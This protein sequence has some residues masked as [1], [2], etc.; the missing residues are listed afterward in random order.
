M[1]TSPALLL[2]YSVVAAVIGALL[3]HRMGEEQALQEIAKSIGGKIND[4]HQL[5]LHVAGELHAEIRRRRTDPVFLLPLLE[6]LGASP[7]AVLREGGCCSGIARLYILILDALGIRAAQVTLYHCSG[8]AVHCLVEVALP[9]G[10]LIVDPMYGFS[11]E[12]SDGRPLGLEDLQQG[13]QPFFKSLPRSKAAA[14]PGDSYYHFSF[15][16]SKTA[17]WTKSKLRRTAYSV[18]RSLTFGRVDR[19]RLSPVLEWPQVLLGLELLAGAAGTALFLCALELAGP[20]LGR[21]M[22]HAVTW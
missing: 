10:Q 13:S 2:V 3:L 21:A 19:I 12:H 18:L 8:R 4:P 1:A 9:I 7:L 6:P 22:A 17:N 20:G 14:Y 5:V 15:R 16:H 11:Y